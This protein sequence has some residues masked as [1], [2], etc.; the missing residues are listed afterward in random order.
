MCVSVRL[1]DGIITY[2][3]TTCQHLSKRLYKYTIFGS[4][5]RKRVKKLPD[6]NKENQES[7]NGDLGNDVI[8][9]HTRC[10]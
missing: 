6:F 8:G 10:K 4:K 3:K 9:Q 5:D 7:R 1:S 2:H